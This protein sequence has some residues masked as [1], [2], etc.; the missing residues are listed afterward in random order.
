MFANLKTKKLSNDNIFFDFV[1][2]IVIA[3]I[4]SLGLVMLFAVIL[5]G[6]ALP[7]NVIA[8][9]TMVIKA[10]SVVFGSFVAVKKG[11]SK[12]L[13]KGASF[14]TVYIVVA[15]LLFSILS[16][17]FDIGLSSVLDL[18]SAAACGGIVGI[19]KVNKKQ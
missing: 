1:K 12:G 6:F 13:V 18:I 11:S 9:I 7:D 3:V 16:G 8:P 17:S 5:K 2:G 19:I 14:G 10:I 4:I 15:F